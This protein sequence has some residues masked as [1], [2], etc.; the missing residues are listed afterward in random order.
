M[1]NYLLK[2]YVVDAFTDKVFSGN[3]AAICLL[4]KWLSDE[5]YYI[6]VLRYIYKINLKICMGAI[7]I[8]FKY[9]LSF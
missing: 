3:P 2:Q 8:A 4:D 7:H 1:E 6:L 9:S 5:L